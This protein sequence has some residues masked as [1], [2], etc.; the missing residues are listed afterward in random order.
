MRSCGED[1]LSEIAK[2]FK[3]GG[4]P[5]SIYAG[6][7]M[8]LEEASAAGEGSVQNWKLREA[9]LLALGPISIPLVQVSS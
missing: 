6:C 3:K 9:S 5:K 7:S 8:R 1:L 4:G 2:S